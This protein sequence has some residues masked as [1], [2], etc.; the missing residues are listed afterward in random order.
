MASEQLRFSELKGRDRLALVAGWLALFV[1]LAQLAL[2]S[3]DIYVRFWAAWLIL[4]LGVV[5]WT[6]VAVRGILELP[7]ARQPP[8]WQ[9]ILSVA[10]GVFLLAEA[11]WYLDFHYLPSDP[12]SQP[13]AELAGAFFF[14]TFGSFFLIVGI[15]LLVSSGLRRRSRPG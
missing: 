4:V 2:A 12:R 9:L 7:L 11:C 6:C 10:S 14:G 5:L 3:S 13:G 15:V 8:V 1:A